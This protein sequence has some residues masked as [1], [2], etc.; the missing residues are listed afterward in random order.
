MWKDVLP[1]HCNKSEHQHQ[2]DDSKW[3]LVFI[4]FVLGICV[5]IMIASTKG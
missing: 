2:N 5:G 1:E 4:F 3:M